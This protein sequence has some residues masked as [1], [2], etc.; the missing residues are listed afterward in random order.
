MLSARLCTRTPSQ[1][2]PKQGNGSRSLAGSAPKRLRAAHTG[3][4]HNS[5][6][7]SSLLPVLRSPAS[8][9]SR[10]P[11]G[12]RRARILES[13]AGLLPGRSLCRMLSAPLHTVYFSCSSPLFEMTGDQT[14]WEHG[15]GR[16]NSS[17][18]GP[19][20]VHHSARSHRQRRCWVIPPTLCSS[21]QALSTR[22]LGTTERVYLILI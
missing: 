4:R 21:S 12:A 18:H 16:A 3:S 14:R 9:A 20:C 19:R 5:Q 11:R 22:N 1:P 15:V 17:R 7:A 2:A 6:H 10:A 13:G 8:S